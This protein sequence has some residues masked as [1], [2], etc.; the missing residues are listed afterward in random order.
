[1][2]QTIS[3]AHVQFVKSWMQ[4]HI[5]D[6][7]K[8]LNMPVLFAEFGVSRKENGYNSS[9]RD[10][11]YN[12]V[13]G[14]ILQSTKKGGSGAGSLLWQLFPEGTEYMDDGYAITLS[15]DSSTS[16]IISLQSTRMMLFNTLC[17]TRCRWICRKKHALED[18]MYHDE[19]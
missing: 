2:S 10:A 7:D 3:D 16:N 19:L 14:K 15:K 18:F 5:D 17:S 12:T 6:A 1:M 13:Y 9:F 11:F 4:A 8:V